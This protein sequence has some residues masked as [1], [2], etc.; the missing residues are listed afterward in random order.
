MNGTRQ[1][2]TIDEAARY[3]N[4]SKSSLRR[5]TNSGRLACHRIGVRGER[6]FAV[7]DLEGLLVTSSIAALDAA[8]ASGSVRHVCSH[9][10]DVE[11]S[12]RLFLPYF[13]YHAERSAPVFYIHDSTS[14]ERFF[15]YVRAAGWDPEELTRRGLLELIHSSQAYLRTGSFSASGMIDFV[16]EAIEKA[17][18]RGHRLMLVSGEMTWSLSGAPGSGEMIEYEERLN[19]LLLNYPDV[20]IV[21]HYST[22]LFGSQLTL[23]ALRAHPL[24][25]LSDRIVP[26]FYGAS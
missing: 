19:D 7:T 10:R 11:E 12:W 13:R 9:F 23:D 22:E 1:L 15:A 8:A 4:V 18:A 2:L 17:R 5:W 20:T 14:R 26:G 21:C 24:V 16:A 3:L 25:Q 6:R